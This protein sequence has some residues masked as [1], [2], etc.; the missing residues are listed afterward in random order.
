ML[1]KNLRI[2]MVIRD[3]TAV[4]LA[5]AL[6]MS[7]ITI[8]FIVNGRTKN[9][10]TETVRALAKGLGVTIEDLYRTDLVNL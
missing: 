1:G 7:P 8:G 6:D 10:R 4:D 5:K 9:P 3:I 2:V